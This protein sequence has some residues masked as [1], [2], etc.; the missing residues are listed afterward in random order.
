MELRRYFLLAPDEKTETLVEARTI[1]LQ[2]VQMLAGMLAVL[3]LFYFLGF[4]IAADGDSP[5]TRQ[6]HGTLQGIHFVSFVAMLLFVG[7]STWMRRRKPGL[8]ALFF[9]EALF[10][11]WVL[12]L[13]ISLAAVDQLVTSNITPFLVAC[14]A[15]GA[16]FHLR[17]PVAFASFTLAGTVFY[18]AMGF[19]Q[20]SAALLQSNRAN[21]ITACILGFGLSMAFWRSFLQ[22][23]AQRARIESQRAELARANGELAHMAFHDALTGLPN[24]R[25]LDERV[26]SEADS[27]RNGATTACLIELDL[28]WFKHVND[29]HGHPVGDKVLRRVAELLTENVRASDTVARLGGEEFMILCPNTSLEG[30]TSLAEKLR[31]RIA[32]ERIGI[33]GRMLRVTAS[34]GVTTL[35]VQEG[36]DPVQGYSDADAAL[37]RAKSLGR[38]RVETTT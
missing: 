33:D 37:Y 4:L 16:V 24:R 8:R 6:W 26:R 14:V 3:N 18:L 10:L 38:N 28:D 9:L 35:P 23:R 2:R 22:Q 34:F 1:N 15:V 36:L 12:S 17:P 13:G 20:D 30:A 5:I 11:F 29:Q 19:T 27:S 32:E 7:A 31:D 21:G 25:Q